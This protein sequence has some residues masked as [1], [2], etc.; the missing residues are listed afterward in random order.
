MRFPTRKHIPLIGLVVH[1]DVRHDMNEPRRLRLATCVLSTITRPRRQ[2][3]R[4]QTTIGGFEVM[5]RQS[6]LTNIVAALHTP[7]RFT[8]RLNG[9]Q[10][11]SHQDADDRNNDQQLDERKSSVFR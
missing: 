3:G 9:W 5:D 4:W 11:Q 1:F 2:P 8:S 10:Q 7:R 6:Q